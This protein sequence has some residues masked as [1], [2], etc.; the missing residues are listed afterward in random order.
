MMG[1]ALSEASMC[2]NPLECPIDGQR[3][4]SPEGHHKRK[5]TVCYGEAMTISTMNE[6]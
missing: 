4:I 2:R 1:L 5:M 6:G 3:G